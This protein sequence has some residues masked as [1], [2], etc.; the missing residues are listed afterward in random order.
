MHSSHKVSKIARKR[1]LKS[2]WADASK[3]NH[4]GK[5]NH[6]QFSKDKRALEEDY[7]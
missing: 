2:Q 7:A 4:T 5:P 3:S 1:P 6:R